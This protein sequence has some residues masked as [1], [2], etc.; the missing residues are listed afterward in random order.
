MP[1]ESGKDVN[2]AI[3]GGGLVGALQAC[4]LAKKGYREVRLYEVMCTKN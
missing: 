1:S 2:V 3:I 4:L